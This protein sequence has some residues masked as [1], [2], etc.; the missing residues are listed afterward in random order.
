MKTARSFRFLRFALAAGICCAGTAAAQSY[1]SKS[2]RL[3]VPYPPGG[4]NDN[5]ARAD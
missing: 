2:I 3:I 4:A 1:P 5:I